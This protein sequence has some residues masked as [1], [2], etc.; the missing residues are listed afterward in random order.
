MDNKESKD[1]VDNI[2]VIRVK[3][4][5]RIK[6]KVEK[7]KRNSKEYI[8]YINDNYSYVEYDD[9]K[10]YNKNLLYDNDYIDYKLEMEKSNVSKSILTD[11][12]ICTVT[13]CGYIDGLNFIEKDLIS[14][15]KPP[16]N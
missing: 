5:R 15:L 1:N 12:E 4:C 3:K 11:L 13:S 7:Y 16:N 8:D 10:I 14:I 9:I 2:D 6:K